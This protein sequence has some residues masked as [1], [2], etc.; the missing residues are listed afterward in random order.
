[1][2]DLSDLLQG[3]NKSNLSDYLGASTETVNG[4]STTVL[5]IS[6]TG[7]LGSEG[8]NQKIVLEGQNYDTTDQAKL[9]QDLISQGKLHVDL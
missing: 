2:L 1:M 4:K 7:H 8:A 5:N 6:T 3:E 9:V